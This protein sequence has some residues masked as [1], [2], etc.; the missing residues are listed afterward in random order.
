MVKKN[1]AMDIKTG[2][3]FAALFLQSLNINFF[4]NHINRFHHH[5]TILL[6]YVISFAYIYR[7][8]YHKCDCIAEYLLKAAKITR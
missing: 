3:I 1:N 5:Y 7:N 2:A 6:Y 4:L 8:C